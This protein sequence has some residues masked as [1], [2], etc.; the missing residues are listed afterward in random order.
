MVNFLCTSF[1]KKLVIVFLINVLD[2]LDVILSV[3]LQIFEVNGLMKA[4]WA[5]SDLFEV[6]IQPKL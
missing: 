3:Q 2:T 4:C 1:E 6:N 5:F